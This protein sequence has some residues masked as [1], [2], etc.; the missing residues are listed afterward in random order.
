MQ[1]EYSFAKLRKHQSSAASLSQ[2]KQVCTVS[3]Q[4]WTQIDGLA[5]CEG[6]HGPQPA[7]QDPNKGP[8][9]VPPQ[10]P[11]AAGSP[12][13]DPTAD[14]PKPSQP[15]ADDAVSESQSDT[16]SLPGEHFKQDS[17]QGTHMVRQ[18]P[19][20]DHGPEEEVRARRQVLREHVVHVTE[21]AACLQ[22]LDS[23]EAECRK[24]TL[25]QNIRPADTTATQFTTSCRKTETVLRCS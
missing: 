2:A 22:G 16:K 19:G 15:P 20:L 4:M 1:P 9:P 5:C 13:P 25:A 14:S 18:A 23:N 7:P 10:T 11:P 21:A 3:H 6:A 8:Q 24:V 17:S 12:Q